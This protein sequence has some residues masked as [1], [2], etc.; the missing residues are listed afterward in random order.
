MAF[1]KKC[2]SQI[3][4]C[5]KCGRPATVQLGEEWLCDECF[6]KMEPKEKTDN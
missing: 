4:I 5:F 6:S 3:K 1:L 2:I